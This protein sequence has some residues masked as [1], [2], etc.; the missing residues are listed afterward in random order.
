[1]TRLFSLT[2]AFLVGAAPVLAQDKAPD[3][4]KPAAPSGRRVRR[5][6]PRAAGRGMGT[7]LDRHAFAAPGVEAVT[8]EPNRPLL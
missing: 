6:P 1:M 7:S 5:D 2:L 8:L 3:A 4:P